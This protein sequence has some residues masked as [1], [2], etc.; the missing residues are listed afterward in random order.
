MKDLMYCKHRFKN[1]KATHS[2]KY[3]C[4]QRIFKSPS[5]IPSLKNTDL[6]I[7][8]GNAIYLTTL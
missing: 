2:K 3:F 8:D 4:K 5:N 7:G 1:A 6:V